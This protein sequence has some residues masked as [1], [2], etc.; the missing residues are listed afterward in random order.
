MHSRRA[1][2]SSDKPP[3]NKPLPPKKPRHRQEQSQD[4][5]CEESRS[6]PGQRPRKGGSEQPA[7][8]SSRAAAAGS[9]KKM[10]L[11]VTARSH[12]QPNTRRR[13]RMVVTYFVRRSADFPHP[14]LSLSPDDS[15]L[16]SHLSLSQS[17]TRGSEKTVP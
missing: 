6:W 13:S 10:Q 16:S 3:S 4:L 15:Y 7:E 8:P 9:R 2:F 11:S 14:G 12:E 17:R 5:G 1:R